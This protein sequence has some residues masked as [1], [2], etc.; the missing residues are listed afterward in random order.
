MTTAFQRIAMERASL[1][2]LA[3]TDFRAEEASLNEVVIIPIAPVVT[4]GNRTPAMIPTLAGD[5]TVTNTSISITKDRKF[6]FY[7]TGDD[8]AR[9][10]QNPDFVPAS[11]L[12]AIRACRNEIHSDLAGLHV[13]AGGWYNTTG[14][15]SGAAYGTAG[16]TPFGSAIDPAPELKKMLEDSLAPLEDRF[17]MI[18]TAAER[19]IGKLNQL[20]KVNEAGTP[21]LLRAGI[22]GRL[23]GF[24]VV[25][26]QDVKLW[27]PVGTGASYV[28]NGTNAAGSTS[29]VVKTGTGTVLAGDA[30]SVVSGGV[31]TLYVVATGIAAAGT[32]VLTSGLIQAAADGD[33]VTVI[34][35]SRRNMAFHREALGLAIRLPKLPPEG[36][37]GQHMVIT[38]PQSGLGFRFSTY[39]GYGA[40]EYEL[41]CAWGVKC[42]RPELLK[43]LLG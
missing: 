15:V 37:A 28:V 1:T 21:D 24:N 5:R 14:G 11:I 42:V 35:A 7:M 40:N 17:L 34:A 18:D 22:V 27:S 32:L 33:V 26:D 43:I 12:Q 3:Q 16:T 19:N 25:V 31:T 13:Q 39:K 38:D 23:S 36:D 20:V 6:P 9:A 10:R 8:F 41:S 4:G 30:I 2:R 29:L